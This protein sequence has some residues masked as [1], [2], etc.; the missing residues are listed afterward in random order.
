MKQTKRS[1]LIDEP[2]EGTPEDYSMNRRA[3]LRRAGKVCFWTGVAG[4]NG[5]ALINILSKQEEPELFEEYQ[6]VRS[7]LR[8]NRS[9]RES[10]LRDIA[11]VEGSNNLMWMQKA[12]ERE[13]LENLIARFDR[14]RLGLESDLKY[15]ESLPPIRKYLSSEKRRKISTKVSCWSMVPFVYGAISILR[16][17]SSTTEEL[18]TTK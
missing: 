18:G 17:L 5:G 14:E 6:N 7:D 8:D 11:E 10:L 12:E 9:Y 13:F 2:Y 4:I 16:N 1:Q 15:L 3:F